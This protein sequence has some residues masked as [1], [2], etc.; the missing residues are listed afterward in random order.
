MNALVGSCWR[1]GECEKEKGQH[2]EIGEKIFD[3]PCLQRRQLSFP[4][5]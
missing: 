4:Q 3:V 1:D 2:V 5:R